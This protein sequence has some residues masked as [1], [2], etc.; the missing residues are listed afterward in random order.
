[1]SKTDNKRQASLHI[2]AQR[3]TLVQL[4]PPGPYEDTSF[5]KLV[6]RRAFTLVAQ[7]SQLIRDRHSHSISDEM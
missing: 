4:H 3:T 2:A 7:H 1:M 6:V 5:N